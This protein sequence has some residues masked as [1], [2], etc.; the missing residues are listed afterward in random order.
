MRAITINAKHGCPQIDRKCKTPS[1]EVRYHGKTSIWSSSR[2]NRHW[3][4][5][6]LVYGRTHYDPQACGTQ[7]LWFEQ[8]LIL[9]DLA[10][11]HLH[12]KNPVW[13]VQQVL[14]SR[15]ASLCSYRVVEEKH[16]P[17]RSGHQLYCLNVGM[18]QSLLFCRNAGAMRS[19]LSTYKLQVNKIKAPFI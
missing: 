16:G 13:W 7:V 4:S 9:L 6:H 1:A 15:I 19:P 11:A 18:S 2:F 17:R 5:G 10:Q 3:F 8:S 12:E 14:S